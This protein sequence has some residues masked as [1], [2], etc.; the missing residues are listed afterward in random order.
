MRFAKAV[1]LL[2]LMQCAMTVSNSHASTT[3]TSPSRFVFVNFDQASSARF[4]EPPNRAA[5]AKVL[6]KVNAA[7]PKAVALKFF[8]DTP[9]VDADTNQ[10]VA[11]I[12][13][14][15]VLLQATINPEP[16]T[17]KLLA[18][19]FYFVGFAGS[20]VPDISG[21]EGWLPIQKVAEKAQKV[22]FVDSVNPERVPML[23]KFQGNLVK[24][25]HACLL[26]EAFDGSTMTFDAS[27]VR[28]GQSKPHGLKVDATGSVAIKLADTSIP[29]TISALG[30][31]DG[32]VADAALQGK[33]V[34]FIYTGTKSPM[35]N[36]GPARLKVHH[37]FAA[38]LREL[39]AL[40]T[41]I[42]K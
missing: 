3:S 37:V 4:G 32:K 39:E 18:D 2:V 33:V 31:V 41:P 19:R 16:P 38:Q 27:R 20:I 40:I 34:V 7:S 24:T 22:C 29:A 11:E 23:E 13:K 8:Y 42:G 25:L 12:A 5:V 15:R 21:H 35:I 28:F 14:G 6:A 30:I 9:G 1:L 17:S 36:V 26:E 10:L